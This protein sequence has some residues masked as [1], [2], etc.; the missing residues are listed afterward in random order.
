M[1]QI[2]AKYQPLD[3]TEIPEVWLRVRG[4]E[5]LFQEVYEIKGIKYFTSDD[6]NFPTSNPI[7]ETDLVIE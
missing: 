2:R 4:K 3:A 5:F 1:N 7:P 6:I